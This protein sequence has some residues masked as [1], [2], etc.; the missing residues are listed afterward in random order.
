M[1]EKLSE[2]QLKTFAFIEAFIAKKGF[3]PTF[4]QIGRHI[5]TARSGAFRYVDELIAAGYIEKRP[6]HNGLQILRRPAVCG[7]PLPGPPTLAGATN[8]ELDQ[9]RR[10]LAVEI[11]RRTMVKA[12]A[13]VDALTEA[14]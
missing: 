2:R 10:D 12:F 13:R 6:G 8:D 5:S 9:L 1:T 14:R 4:E 11:S 3:A 7:L